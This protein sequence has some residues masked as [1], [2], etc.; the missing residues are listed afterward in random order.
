M[1]GKPLLVNGMHGLGDNIYE[2]AIIRQLAQHYTVFLK[3]PWPAIFHDMPTVTLVNPASN[4]RTQRKNT[5]REAHKYKPA[6]PS[7]A[8]IARVWYR[9][10]DIPKYGSLP[11]AMIG[12]VQESLPACPLDSADFRLP[13]P[14]AWRQRARDAVGQHDKPLLVYRPLTVRTEW[15]SAG[16]RNPDAEAYTQLLASIRDR[17]FVVSVADLEDGQEWIV[18]PRV[19]ADLE[20]HRGQLDVEAI[21]GLFSI[22]GLIFAAPG[23]AIA[24]AQAVGTP[25]VIVFGGHESSASY[26]RAMIWAPVLMIDP[27]VP[28]DCFNGNHQCDKRIDT[29]A[30]IARLHDFVGNPGTTRSIA[31]A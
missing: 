25:S 26:R 4:L 27:V 8:Q 17:Y 24:M 19:Q 13:V 18:G 3:T 23:F 14:D 29:P 30:A 21:A 12:F 20:L 15:G 11:G 9:P 22:A 1:V 10:A 7:T 28:C 2:R 6:P 5:A 16:Q 31:C